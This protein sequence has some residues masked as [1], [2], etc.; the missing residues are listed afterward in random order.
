LEI[1]KNLIKISIG[2][3]TLCGSGTWTLGK[4][5]QRVINALGT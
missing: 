2:S 5:E 1:K 3:V 4:I